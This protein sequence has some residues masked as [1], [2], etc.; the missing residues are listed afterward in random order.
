MIFMIAFVE[1]KTTLGEFI[2]F[3]VIGGGH[4]TIFTATNICVLRVAR[5]KAGD[6]LP[7][8]HGVVGIGALSSPL[9]IRILEIKAFYLVA[10]VYFVF[11]VLCLCNPAPFEEDSEL[12]N[13]ES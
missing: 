2:S 8:V 7:I 5:Q 3:S 9:L 12:I 10:G 11:S 4:F 1:W 13:N 6:W